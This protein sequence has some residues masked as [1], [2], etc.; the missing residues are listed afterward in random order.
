MH[1]LQS[2]H[3]FA[4]PSHCQKLVVVEAPEQLKEIDFEPPF[5]IL[6]EGS[7]CVF[8]EDF[9]G[10]V[11]QI[12]NRGI[13]ITETELHYHVRAAAGENWHQLVI[14]LLN[15]GIGGLENLAL[16]PGTVG[17]APVQN[18]GAYGVELADVFDSLTGFDIA[19]RDFVQL[20]KAQCQFGYRD[21]VFK[22]PLQGQF[23]ITEVTL[24]LP[25]QWQP[26]L[27]YGPLKALQG[28]S[29][30][31]LSVAE[32]VMQIRRSKLPDPT[33]CANAGSFFKNPVVE[34]QI[35][36]TLK[37][38]YP[39]MPIYPVTKGKVKLAAGWLIEQAGLKD[40]RIGGIRV[41]DKQALVLV[42]DQQGDGTELLAMIAHIQQSVWDKFAVALIPEVRLIAAQGEYS[43]GSMHG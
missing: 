19:K 22:G 9:Q 43:A 36:D 42:N 20:N 33:V 10:S 5:F 2:L 4:L 24:K 27:A 7:N 21:S 6:G 40:H 30:N 35:V 41:Y 31:P 15:M 1:A 38:Q 29:V 17:A 3:T 11:V 14:K 39:D 34:A 26:I 12:A 16:I 23:V 13:E 18:I 8:L 25:K 37:Q 28:L 32:R